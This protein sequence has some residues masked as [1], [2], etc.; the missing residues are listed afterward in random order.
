MNTSRICA[1]SKQTSINITMCMSRLQSAPE[2][3]FPLKLCEV[4]NSSTMLSE[5]QGNIQ[6][7]WVDECKSVC[8]CMCGESSCF[9]SIDDIY[10]KVK[11]TETTMLRGQK[12][13]NSDHV[14]SD[15][16]LKC[17][18]EEL[19]LFQSD[20]M[21]LDDTCAGSYKEWIS[22]VCFAFMAHQLLQ[23]I[24]CQICPYTNKQLYLKQFCFV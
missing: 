3:F 11:R 9:L 16:L 14:R 21:A 15:G 1:M 23:D 18:R 17:Q 13:Q 7:P 6:R 4:V 22:L 8:I 2:T 5:R 19:P 10:F 12:S 24:K 20:R